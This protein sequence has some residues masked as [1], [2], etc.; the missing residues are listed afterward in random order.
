MWRW[1][2]VQADP[3]FVLHPV[4]AGASD[5]QPEVDEAAAGGDLKVPLVPWAAQQ[6]GRRAPDRD[7]TVELDSADDA[8]EE[9]SAAPR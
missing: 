9:Q 4:D 1:W 8:P 5:S 6:A 2:D 7:A 3:E